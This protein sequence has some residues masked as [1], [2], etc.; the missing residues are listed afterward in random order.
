M[1]GVRGSTLEQWSAVS[2]QTAAEMAEGGAGEASAQACLSATGYAGPPSGPEDHTVGHVFLGCSYHGIVSV[3]EHWYRGER[4]EV[5][6]QAM[7]DALRLLRKMIT[8]DL[9]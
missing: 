2:A 3:E 6:A 7:N 4:N 5:R 1:V 9:R 8:A